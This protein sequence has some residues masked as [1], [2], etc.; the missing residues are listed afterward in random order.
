MNIKESIYLYGEGSNVYEI[1]KICIFM[2]R[3]PIAKNIYERKKKD[4][5]DLII[6]KR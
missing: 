3:T 5:N 1:R 2:N 4:R 6:K